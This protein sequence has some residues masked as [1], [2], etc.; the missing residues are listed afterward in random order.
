M[1]P[2][3]VLPDRLDA[4][5]DESF[6]GLAMRYAA[7][8]RF[9]DAR[10]IFFRLKL[11]KNYLETYACLNPDAEEG[12]AVRRLMHI[13][14]EAF[15]L[16]SGWHPDHMSVRVHGH[17]MSV[18][19]AGFSVRQSCPACLREQPYHRAIWLIAALPV[20]AKHGT[21]LLRACPQC[22]EPLRWL[23][24]GVERCNSPACGIDLR[25]AHQETLPDGNLV[26]GRAL[27]SLFN[28]GHHTSGLGFA[29][30]LHASLLLG[31]ARDGRP[32]RGR[33]ARLITNRPDDLPRLLTQGWRVLDPWPEAFRGFL[34]EQLQA[35]SNHVSAGVRDSM[36]WLGKLL[37]SAKTYPWLAV[38]RRETAKYLA[39]EPTFVVKPSV[40]RSWGC[41]AI[42]DSVPLSLSEAAK[43]VGLTITKL[44]QAAERLGVDLGPVTSKTSPRK[45]PAELVRQI[46]DTRKGGTAITATDAGRILGLP[47]RS[48]MQLA[49]AGF[50]TEIP[51]SKRVSIQRCLQRDEVEALLARFEAKVGRLPSVP[52]PSPN[53]MK[54]GVGKKKDGYGVVFL[55]RAVF[56]DEMRPVAVWSGQT[57]LG[58]Y[59]FAPLPTRSGR[60]RRRPERG[61][62]GAS[63]VV[64]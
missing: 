60:S 9:D 37:T 23:G 61:Q 46:L 11:G 6:N 19:L 21:P 5:G 44:R 52:A 34:A 40:L 20:C 16:M 64:G 39:T 4:F 49:Q 27:A 29:D 58:R 59:L 12:D 45:V 55:M 41:D 32:V 54:F 22:G 43:I 31:A 18:D 51:M 10:D 50:L 8:Y 13:P 48:V 7:I 35:D 1:I 14:E 24:R 63:Q 47:A 36:G 57:G 3:Y 62:P 2:D 30:A 38:L 33:P 42:R 25:E 15:R 53:H 28:G 56:G 26:G 17:A